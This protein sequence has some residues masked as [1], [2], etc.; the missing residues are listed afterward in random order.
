[1]PALPSR[2]AIR[3]LRRRAT[4]VAAVAASVAALAVAGA[5]PAAANPPGPHDPLGSV[6]TVQAVQGGLVMSGWAFDPDARASNDGLVSVVDGRSVTVRTATSLPYPSVQSTYG[7]GPTPGF[8]VVVPVPSGTH[9]ACLVARNAGAGIDTVLTCVPTPYGTSL[10]SSQAAAHS[11]VGAITHAWAHSASIHFFGWASD[12]D[13]VSRRTTVVLYVDNSPAATVLTTSFPAPRPAAAGYRSAFDILL[14][15]SPG[16]HLGCL[17][18][19]NVGIG[20][21]KFLGCRAVDT[22]GAPGTAPVTTPTLNTQV[23]AEA[24]RHIGQP[25]VWGATGPS[26]FDCSGLV[27]YSYTKYGYVPPRVS[28]SQFTA[29]RLIPASRAVPGDLVFTHD[30]E[31]D[32]YHV[33]IYVSPGLSV[34]AIDPASGVDYQRIWDPANTTYGSF[35]HT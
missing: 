5:T 27:V 19:V 22:R 29:A 9:T 6:R 26:Q 33:G 14:P 18:A 35:T 7:T 10:S 24:K 17:W 21:N 30:S 13:W 11:P 32:V 23:V 3:E 28:E 12:P 20:S 8:R 4:A 1:M 15:A 34:A 31:G 16:A 25:Y 2:H